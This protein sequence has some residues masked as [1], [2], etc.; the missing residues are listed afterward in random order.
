MGVLAKRRSVMQK[1]R[2]GLYGALTA[3]GI[4]W[5]WY[6][7]YKFV[8]ETEVLG[9]TDPIEIVNL[10]FSWSLGQCISRFHRS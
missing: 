10:F 8:K 5:P 9:L 3:A 4:G 6:C 7:I 2:L 1:L